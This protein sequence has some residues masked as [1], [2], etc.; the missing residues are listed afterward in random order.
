MRRPVVACVAF[1]LGSC[2]GGGGGGSPVQLTPNAAPQ[3]TSATSFSVVE[4]SAQVT[5]LTATDANND[6]LTYSIAGGAD[7]AKFL[8]SGAQLAFASAPNF[9]APSDANSDN[10]F[11]VTVAVSDGRSTATAA[12]TVNVENSREGV[13]VRRIGSIGESWVGAARLVDGSIRLLSKGSI[14]RFDET[15]E[16]LTRQIQWSSASPASG[17]FVSITAD[18]SAL[19][20]THMLVAARFV[21]GRLGVFQLFANTTTDFQASSSSAGVINLAF[22]PSVADVG[23]RLAACPSGNAC[24]AFGSLGVP[25]GETSNRYGAVVELVPNPDPYTGATPGPFYFIT[26]RSAGLRLPTAITL[27]PNPN[28][29]PNLLVVDQGTTRY[30]EVNRYESG[31]TYDFGWPYREGT[32]VM[33]AGGPSQP[34]DPELQLGRGTGVFQTAGLTAAAY[35][36]GAI[37][38]VA[39]KALIADRSGRIFA[40]ANS[41]F[42]N[43]VTDGSSAFE[44]RTLDFR[45]DAGSIGHVAA[46]LSLGSKLLILDS[47]GELFILD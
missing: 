16:A 5:T 42:I 39:G 47:D 12:I 13:S 22:D 7:A 23:G 24:V 17:Q 46:L 44:N 2:G 27:G 26:V 21:D 11:E 20:N 19:I 15:S 10:I 34:T 35:Y 33:A 3:F 6:A 29:A 43:G 1:L 31:L 8:I 28:V 36:Q 40:A 4:N 41:I 14:Y 38:S 18:R 32:E 25:S 37:E 9:D 30:D 45:P